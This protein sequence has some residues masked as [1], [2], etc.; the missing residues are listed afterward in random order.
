M[1]PV[2]P[3]EKRDAIDMPPRGQVENRWESA[4]WVCLLD[5]RANPGDVKRQK[6]PPFCV[7]LDLGQVFL[8]FL[9]SIISPIIP[10]SGPPPCPFP[11]GV[12]YV[13][14]FFVNNYLL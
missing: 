6:V 7:T 5:A 12:L 3:G 2:G 14:Y 1:D 11:P 9:L 10:I 4:S 13:Y 8:I